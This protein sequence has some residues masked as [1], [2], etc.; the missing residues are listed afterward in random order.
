MELKLE[1][2][3]VGDLIVIHDKYLGIVMKVDKW[4]LESM[5]INYP[6]KENQLFVTTEKYLHSIKKATHN[7]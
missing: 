7:V 5:A 3:N 2:Y 6:H 4:S 1:N